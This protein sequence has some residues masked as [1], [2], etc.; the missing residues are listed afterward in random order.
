[1]ANILLIESHVAIASVIKRLLSTDHNLIMMENVDRLTRTSEDIC[2]DVILF[3]IGLSISF[4]KFVFLKKLFPDTPLVIIDNIANYQVTKRYFIEG[5][6]G[7]ISH[8]S[9]LTDLVDCVDAVSI[10]RKYISNN[11][12]VVMLREESEGESDQDGLSIQSGLTPRQMEIASYIGS[13]MRIADIGKL[14]GLASSTV[15]TTK[16]RIYEK[17]KVN[18]ILELRN[19]LGMDA[20]G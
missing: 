9:L 10:G 5:A 2:P 17:L 8:K 14:L 13:A 11:D 19:M 3:D 7:Y 15:S 12:L 1:M 4:L 18:N 6:A 20:R 16:K